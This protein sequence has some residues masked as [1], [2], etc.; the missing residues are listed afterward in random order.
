MYHLSNYS[1]R[2]KRDANELE[3]IV[4]H[5]RA[6]GPDLVTSREFECVQTGN[7]G[8][9]KYDYTIPDKCY[10]KETEFIYYMLVNIYYILSH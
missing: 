8:Y 7:K 3:S 5:P 10:S 6:A 2:K 1:G 4:R 9:W